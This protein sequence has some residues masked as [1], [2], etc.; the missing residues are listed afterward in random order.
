MWSPEHLARLRSKSFQRKTKHCASCAHARFRHKG[1]NSISLHKVN[2]I[3]LRAS[4]TT[5]SA[6]L[7]RIGFHQS[8]TR[9]SV[10][11]WRVCFQRLIVC[12]GVCR[13]ASIPAG[14]FRRLAQGFLFLGKCRPGL[15]HVRFQRINRKCLSDMQNRD[16][17]QTEYSSAHGFL[18]EWVFTKRK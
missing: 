15:Q 7:L 9:T 18:D 14:S 10:F 16:S 3:C 17:F 13:C 2:C 4:P 6:K 8:Q 5:L 12:W 1:A 11:F